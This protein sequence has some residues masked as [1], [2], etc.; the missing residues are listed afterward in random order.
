MLCSL[1]AL[2]L[3]LVDFPANHTTFHEGQPVPGRGHACLD[4]KLSIGCGATLTK[5]GGRD[6]RAA[7]EGYEVDRLIQLARAARQV[8][9]LDGRTL[10]RLGEVWLL[11]QHCDRRKMG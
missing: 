8:G 3:P 5:A 9:T 7:N 10:S 11:A 1:T 4:A 2:A 6:G